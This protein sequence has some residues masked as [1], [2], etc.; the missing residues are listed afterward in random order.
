MANLQKIGIKKI[1]K[2][3]SIESC[4]AFYCHS[5]GGLS[6]PEEPVRPTLNRR[7]RFSAF[8]LRSKCSICSYQLNIWYG[9]HV[10]PSILIWFLIGD[11]DLELARISFAGRPG[12]AVPPGQASSPLN[13]ESK[14]NHISI[15]Y[16]V[17]R[18]YSEIFFYPTYPKKYVSLISPKV[19]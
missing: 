15:W 19:W 7:H 18:G 6:R 13:M 1:G 11:W 5:R 16:R 8:W 12:I 10:L 3:S 17:V 9:S 14:V 2:C 4:V